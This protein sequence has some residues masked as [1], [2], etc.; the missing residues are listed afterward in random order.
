M[1]AKENKIDRRYVNL[2]Y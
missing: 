2:S 1:E